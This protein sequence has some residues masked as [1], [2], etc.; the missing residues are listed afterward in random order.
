MSRVAVAIVV[1]AVGVGCG[2]KAAPEAPGGRGSGDAAAFTDTVET[3]SETWTRH[4]T[5]KWS[6]PTLAVAL[7]RVVVADPA[8]QAALDAAL[9]PEA[10]LGDPRARI[11]ADGWVD[12]VSFETTLNRAHIV[13]FKVT[14]EGSGAYPD[15]F[16]RVV[17]L[18]TLSG[19]RI[20]PETFSDTGKPLLIE[21]VQAEVNVRREAADPEVRELIDPVRFTEAELGSF[22][23]TEPGLVFTIPWGLPHA[24]VAAEPS[25]D[26]TVVWADALP[27]LVPGSP[28]R[29]LGPP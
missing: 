19:A 20:G 27:A 8:V 16:D 18:D 14:V 26:V 2:G 7:P 11:E 4:N 21:R 9:T 24:M 15:S 17:V 22:L 1:A 10:L 29:R 13:S 12:A 3:V 28:L 23:A 25:R 5:D 6:G